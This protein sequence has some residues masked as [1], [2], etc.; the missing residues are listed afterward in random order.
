MPFQKVSVE[1][2]ELD[3]LAGLVE[4]VMLPDVTGVLGNTL[5]TTEVMIPYV[6]AVNHQTYHI[7]G[8]RKEVRT[9][10]ASSECPEQVSVLPCMHLHDPP[11]GRHSSNFLNKVGRKAKVASV[12]TVPTSLQKPTSNPDGASPS[13]NH[14]H[15][16]L[17][18]QRTA[19]KRLKASRVSDSSAV[20]G[21]SG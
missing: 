10:T 8:E 3:P 4:N 20:I 15:V 1:I 14:G 21:T 12:S 16:V 19:L 6:P 9:T 18:H 17:P 11:I 13:N 7:V 2:E 5:T